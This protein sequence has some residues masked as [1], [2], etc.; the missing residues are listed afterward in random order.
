MPKFAF[1]AAIVAVSLAAPASAA[2]A[3]VAGRWI[4]QEKNAVVE[5]GQCGASVC[6][7]IVKFLVKPATG[8]DATDA[9]NPDPKLKSRK[10]L[11]TPIL[12]GFKPEGTQWRGQIY[13]P[14][15]GKTYRSIMQLSGGK[16]SVKG[17]IGPFC[18]NQT[19]TKAG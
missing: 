1:A 9:N 14:K 10:L 11:G 5:I 2:P 16:L 3:S 6:G 18:K 19:W 17:C 8:W 7:R 4:T 12:T 13:D 15:S